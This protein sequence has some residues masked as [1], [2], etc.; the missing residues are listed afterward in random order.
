MDEFALSMFLAALALALGCLIWTLVAE[1]LFRR[2]QRHLHRQIDRTTKALARVSGLMDEFGPP[3]F[4][5]QLGQEAVR[6]ELPFPTLIAGSKTSWL[7]QDKTER[8]P[9]VFGRFL[10][11]IGDNQRARLEIALKKL[12]KDGSAFQMMLTYFDGRSLECEGLPLAGTVA[13]RITSATEDR[14]EIAKLEQ[15]LSAAE[16]ERSALRTLLDHLP[17]PVWRRDADGTLAWVNPAFAKCVSEASPAHAVANRV[18]IEQGVAELAREA[19]NT[20]EAQKERRY[21]IDNGQRRAMDVI[22]VAGKESGGGIAL[23]ATALNDT[24]RKLELHLTNQHETLNSMSTPVA[25]FDTERTLQFFNDAF[26]ELWGLEPDF[27]KN[28]PDHGEVLEQLR[29]LGRLPEQSDFRAWRDKQLVFYS[30]ADESHEDM[31]HLPDGRTIKIVMRHHPNGG[32]VTLFEDMSRV[33]QLESSYNILQGVQRTTLDNLHEGVAA[34]SSDGVLKLFNAAF[35][36]MWDLVPAQIADGVH[37]DRISELCRPLTAN[38]QVW[39]RISA[40]VVDFSGARRSEE[41]RL[42]RN[43][44][45]VLTYAIQPL[46]DGAMLLTFLDVTDS[47]KIERALRDRNEALEAADR[48][49]S[50]FIS[51]VSYQ[52]RDPLNTILGFAEMLETG[53]AGNLQPKQQEYADAISESARQLTDLVND[54]LD[55]AMVEAGAMS[56]ELAKVDIYDTLEAART[57]AVSRARDSE[58]TVRID[59]P[60]DIGAIDADERRLRQILFNLTSNAI[61]FNQPGGGVELSAKRTSAAG[62]KGVEISVRDTGSGISEKHRDKVF[63]SFQNKGGEGRGGAGLGL[64]LVRS[65]VQLHGGHVSLQSE[66]GEGTTVTVFL[67][68]RAD[69]ETTRPQAA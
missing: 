20:G 58:I 12:L 64:A 19:R 1:I 14:K 69:A 3:C 13:M 40:Q 68:E 23:D 53:I 2:R 15:A 55:L 65:F 33:V 62:E 25:I 32:I 60:K 41:G 42:E 67:P 48:L 39:D 50:E 46:P 51:N 30:S 59:C 49:K 10:S 47:L 9:T 43:D 8:V 38:P 35:A 56:L 34:F 66:E 52:L 17:M 5:W 18:E 36:E 63:E 61:H 22:E 29:S 16:S 7:I 28:S 44:G 31:W 6:E 54:I 24:E 26:M 37:W 11:N 57:L 21:V 27:L 45:R 4:V